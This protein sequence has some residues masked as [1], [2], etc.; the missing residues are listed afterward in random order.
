MPRPG[1]PPF[2][3]QTHEGGAGELRQPWKG[4]FTNIASMFSTTNLQSSV[5]AGASP[6]VY[7]NTSPGSPQSASLQQVFVPALHVTKVEFGRKDNTGTLVYTTFLTN[8]PVT[9]S[10]G[11]TLR[12]TW[13]TAAPTII[14]SPL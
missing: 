13:N 3:I 12:I 9:L 4:W 8:A 6:W 2:N 14:V 10:A 11:D 5:V 1:T 7:T